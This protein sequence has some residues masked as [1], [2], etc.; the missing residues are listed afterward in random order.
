MAEL[1]PYFSANR[2]VREYVDKLYSRAAEQFRRR[3]A[4][5]AQ[6]AVLQC[7]WRNSLAQSWHK[8]RF[9]SLDIQSQ[10]NSHIV[11]VTV[12]LNGI[13]PKAVQVQ[14][15]ADPLE[16]T[17]PEIHVMEM[18]SAIP[19][20][21]NGYIYSVRIPA[22]RPVEHYTPRLIPYFDGVVVPI[23]INNILWYE[24]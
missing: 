11:A 21:E 17:E 6:E 9:G 7:H 18:A 3:T 2:M 4:D 10:D 12:F 13:D 24:R 20:T 1:T 5:K 8:L 19:G 15:Y 16:G 14:L 22:R 23:E